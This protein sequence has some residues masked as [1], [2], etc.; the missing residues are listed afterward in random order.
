MTRISR[1]PQTK[2][3][4]RMRRRPVPLLLKNLTRHPPE[5]QMKI[6]V[7]ARRGP[8]IKLQLMRLRLMK[9]QLRLPQNQPQNRTLS[10]RQ[11]L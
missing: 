6:P 2:K 5:A 4:K 11:S 10:A 3:Q 8:R 9:L 1:K 7:K